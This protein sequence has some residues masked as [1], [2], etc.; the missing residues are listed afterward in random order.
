MREK[1]ARLHD[2]VEDTTLLS[3]RS[4]N[5]SDSANGSVNDVGVMLTGKRN[6]LKFD[7]GNIEDS[8]Q[9]SMSRYNIPN[10]FIPIHTILIS[11]STVE[12]NLKVIVNFHYLQCIKMPELKP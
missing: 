7:V 5:G 3:K 4:V 2:E 11:H 6:L 1:T 8:D 9:E 10:S 12:R